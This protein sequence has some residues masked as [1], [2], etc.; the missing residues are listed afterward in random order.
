MRLNF[1]VIGSGVPIGLNHGHCPIKNP[2]CP[3]VFSKP[4]QNVRYKPNYGGQCP[5][6]TESSGHP[7]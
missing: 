5:I 3:I 4:G 7:R 2:K 1:R 6:V